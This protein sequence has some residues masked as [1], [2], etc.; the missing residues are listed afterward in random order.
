M[1]WGLIPGCVLLDLGLGVDVII[2]ATSL[3]VMSK[4][5]DGVR[6]NCPSCS[7]CPN[8]KT[9]TCWRTGEEYGLCPSYPGP[10]AESTPITSA[11]LSS[12]SGLE[13]DH[14][15]GIF[16]L[17]PRTLHN[18]ISEDPYY[19]VSPEKLISLSFSS[20]I[21]KTDRKT[22]IKLRYKHSKSPLNVIDRFLDTAT[23]TNFTTD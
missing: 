8:T 18:L 1:L 12:D 19:H 11:H 7:F 2:L 17:E 15:H 14:A 21:C 13:S 22:S 4:E 6:A 23:L 5:L 10:D 20:F 3:R 9:R 16:G